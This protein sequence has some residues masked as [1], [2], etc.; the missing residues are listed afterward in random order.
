MDFEIVVF[1]VTHE[2]DSLDAI[3]EIEATTM[4]TGM[5][6]AGQRIEEWT[7]EQRIDLLS[8]IHHF[9]THLVYGT[10]E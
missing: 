5:L 8:T 7:R 4:E 9:E 10:Q 6:L 1:P 3:A 2:S